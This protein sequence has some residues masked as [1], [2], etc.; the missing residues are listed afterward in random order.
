MFVNLKPAASA[1]KAARP[2]SRGCARNWREVTG[3]S[4][5]L[6]TVQDLRSGGRATNS[7]Y[8]Y[9]L[10]SDN[11]ADLRLWALKLAETMKQQPR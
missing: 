3:I 1:P 8:Q 7:T 10:K 9:T 11:A 5:F 2:S 4:L 6:G